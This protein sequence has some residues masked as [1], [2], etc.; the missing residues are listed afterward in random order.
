[1]VMPQAT[2]RNWAEYHQLHS[3]A[4]WFPIVASSGGGDASSENEPPRPL[5][6]P[7]TQDG[8][9]FRLEPLTLLTY[10]VGPYSVPL[11]SSGL[12]SS[13]SLILLDEAAHRDS[14]GTI[15]WPAATLVASVLLTSFGDSTDRVVLEL[16]CGHGF[17]GL[18]ARR[19]AER[20]VLSD[21]DPAMRALAARN[22][23]LQPE[24]VDAVEAY[25]WGEGD[26]WP[27]RGQF[28]LV[29]ASEVFYSQTA[30]A[31]RARD[32]AS[33]HGDARLDA[34]AGWRG[35][36][37]PCRAPR[38][39]PRRSGDGAPR[40]VCGHQARGGR[41]RPVRGSR[42]QQ[43]WPVLRGLARAHVLWCVRKRG[44]HTQRRQPP[45]APMMS[46]AG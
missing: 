44:A 33:V 13:D 37:R 42:A 34:H 32:A 8:R 43:W 4:N 1:M 41:V 29:L 45:P 18:V 19:L 39:R 9:S 20:V 14:T 25:G 15:L 16:G 2:P 3:A 11:L 22:S 28:G 23:A 31:A 36:P 6:V 40:I 35:H 21:R 27:P 46:E 38:Q 7:L 26:P 17:C 5:R 30:R 12:V 24:P 10:S